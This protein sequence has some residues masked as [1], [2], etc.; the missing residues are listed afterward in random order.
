MLAA[1]IPALMG[2]IGAAAEK[3]IPD[4]QAR[5]NF[6]VQLYGLLQQS[7]LSQ[8]QVNQA[9]A[10]SGSSFVAGWRPAIGWV[11]AIALGYQYLAVPL[12]VWGTSW[13]GATTQNV[14]LLNMPS[15]P[16]LD[17]NLW[18]LM[19]GMLGMGALRSFEKLKGVANR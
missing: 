4:P 3:L 6:M 5:Q 15:P 9:E 16:T 7:D 2:I 19:F 1:F 12:F 11:C 14:T 13:V 17:N 8:L 18:E 10:R